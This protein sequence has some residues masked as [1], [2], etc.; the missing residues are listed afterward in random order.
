MVVHRAGRE[1]FSQTVPRHPFAEPVP[2]ARPPGRFAPA[3]AS[4]RNPA[5]SAGSGIGI[6]G[7]QSGRR[8]TDRLFYRLH[9]RT[10]D[11]SPRAKA[12]FLLRASARCDSLRLVPAISL[13]VE[14][15]SIPTPCP[16]NNDYRF[17]CA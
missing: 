1:N 2:A 17:P 4:F 16:P 6:D 12:R 3:S 13:A 5:P 10:R 14:P 8:E 15:N 11:V 7:W 9:R